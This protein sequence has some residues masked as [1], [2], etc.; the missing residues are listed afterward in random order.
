MAEC[1]GMDATDLG[2]HAGAFCAYLLDGDCDLGL[3]GGTVKS[4]RARHAATGS[5]DLLRGAVAAVMALLL[6]A[7]PVVAD[8]ATVPLTVEGMAARSDAVVIANV[9]SATAHQV[10]SRSPGE[11]P[12][13]VTDAVLSVERVLKG[14]RGATVL[15]T[16]EGG[17]AGGIGVIADESPSFVPGQRCVLFLDPAGGVVGGKR[18]KADIAGDQVPSEGMPLDEFLARVTEGP[19]PEGGLR[20]ATVP[21]LVAGLSS[22]GAFLPAITGISPEGRPAG[23]YS[24]V[25]V[26][27]VGFG[28]AAGR[29]YFAGEA[30]ARVLA[31]IV[32][33]SW[34][35]TS[36]VCVVPAG[37]SSGPVTVTSASFVRSAAYPYVVGFSWL[38]LHWD[39]ADMPYYVDA[40]DAASR[41]A[42][43]EGAD[44]WSGVSPTHFSFAVEPSSTAPPGA[45]L[46]NDM[47]W[48][49]DYGPRSTTLA[50]NHLVYNPA[51][52]QV[53]HSSITFN[54][55]QEWG[56]GE[57]ATFSVARVAAHEL[58]HS[59]AIADQYGDGD[60]G[61]LMYWLT[62][63]YVTFKGIPDVDADGLRW[64]YDQAFTGAD[65]TADPP[66]LVRPAPA[67]TSLS[68]AYSP[69]RPRVRRWLTLRGAVAP[70]VAGDAVTIRM[71]KP[72]SRR[73][74]NVAVVAADASGSW[75]WRYRP[76]VR[77]TFYFRAYYGGAVERYG[78]WSRT[79]SVRVR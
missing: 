48:V 16:V 71:R 43:I 12:S 26:S 31:P 6:L 69:R 59:L 17:R 7:S 79:M 22:M 78:S 47:R 51:T 64:I 68:I 53:V 15:L 13:V 61:E 62:Y 56:D 32:S 58:G 5:G 46:H 42:V 67:A 50:E 55:W 75:A 2:S 23:T 60:K 38:G 3:Q 73:W 39:G 33:G 4:L 36:V 65:P 1:G 27:G 34:T 72:R 10:A 44:A 29:V 54:A 30:G 18:G 28:T 49:Y 37:A 45:P 14:A 57:G 74:T 19:V 41:A 8:G 63:Q 66:T 77:G 70:G 40:P 76:R 24:V 21:E 52:G 25:T 20:A 11:P 9:M 35:E